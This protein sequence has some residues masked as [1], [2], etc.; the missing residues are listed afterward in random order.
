MGPSYQEWMELAAEEYRRLDDLLRG[1]TPEQ[2]RAATVCPGW[3]VRAM[4]AHLVGA[5]EA[6]ASVRELARQ[7]ASSRRLVP[8][9]MLVDKM[10]DLQVRERAARTPAE[11][12]DDLAAAAG[13]GLRGRRR[14]PAALRAVRM[15]FGPP[16]GVRRLDYLYG[17]IYTRDAWMHRLDVCAATGRAPEVTAGHDG[18]LVA[19]V[20]EE[21]AAAH[22]AALDLVLTGPAGGHWQRGADA[23]RVEVDALEMCRL[24]SGRGAGVGLLAHTVPF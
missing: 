15:P 22:D 21:W 23:E 6:T 24:V 1:L 11:L 4:V 10:N 8:G 18:V 17:R 14:I 9:G 16:R 3:D 5:A 20:V 12:V 7:A 2:W 19:D 13:R